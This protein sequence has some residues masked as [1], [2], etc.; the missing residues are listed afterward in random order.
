MVTATGLENWKLLSRKQTQ[1]K[2]DTGLR[3][4][5]N[6]KEPKRATST[7]IE[8]TVSHPGTAPSWICRRKSF[9]ST[10]VYWGLIKETFPSSKVEMAIKEERS[11]KEFSFGITTQGGG[12]TMRRWIKIC[13]QVIE[14]QQKHQ[15]VTIDAAPT[16]PA[17]VA[18]MVFCWLLPVELKT[19]YECDLQWVKR[20]I[21]LELVFHCQHGT[22]ADIKMSEIAC[23]VTELWIK[24]CQH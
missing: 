7:E 13:K 4:S 10:Y 17:V 19:S 15:S 21:C 23:T 24:E 3:P 8:G 16:S 2:G 5:G 1:N 18:S 14:K 9:S 20:T 12:R 6:W 22:T 11:D